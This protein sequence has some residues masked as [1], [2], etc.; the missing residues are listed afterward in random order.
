MPKV[1]LEALACGIPVVTTDVV[2]CRDS[3][4]NNYNGY[5]VF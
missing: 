5:C 4:L 1:V 3:I 2:G